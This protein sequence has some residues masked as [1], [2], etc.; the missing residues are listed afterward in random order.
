[1]ITLVVGPSDLEL[2][3]VEVGGEAH[4]HLFRARRLERGE[5]IRLV[6]GE[7][8]ARW[9][10]VVSV[11]RR[12]AALRL[13]E[14]APSGEPELQLTLVVGALRPERASWLVEKATE[15]GV[16]RV[17]WYCSERSRRTFGAGTL[18]RLRR[19]A[20]AAVE[21]CG[22]SRTP[23]IEGMLEWTEVLERVAS[24]G[25]IVL[26]PR[27]GGEAAGLPPVDRLLL[28]VGP[29]GGFSRAE[30]TEL[31]D[32]GVQSWHLGERVLRVETA[33]LVGSALL[34]MPSPA[35]LSPLASET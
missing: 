25:S 28:L 11:D 31:G 17:L 21:Q 1:M 15:I 23:E 19:V 14:A 3:T 34:L 20:R 6:D 24:E 13:Q 22:R 26:D 10:E 16:S 2:D 30:Q 8:R 35:E 12:S 5:R 27:A 9:S 29:E 7:G 18:D 33:A 32:R 4:R